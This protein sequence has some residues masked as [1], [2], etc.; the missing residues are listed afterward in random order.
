[1]YQITY[2]I[3]L[4]CKK[5]KKNTV[6]NINDGLECNLTERAFSIVHSTRLQ[7]M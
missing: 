5:K 3:V 4:Y 1:M 6:S 7:N 2:Y